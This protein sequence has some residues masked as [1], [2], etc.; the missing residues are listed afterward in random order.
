MRSGIVVPPRG[1]C[2][3]VSICKFIFASLLCIPLIS[4]VNDFL[5]CNLHIIYGLVLSQASTSNPRIL[6]RWYFKRLIPL[7]IVS[8]QRLHVNICILGSSIG[9]P[10]T[11]IGSN[12]FDIL[13]R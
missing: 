11:Q 4:H 12:G 13:F 1:T 8:S 7:E 3:N 6:A 9:S 5:V 10:Y 2:S